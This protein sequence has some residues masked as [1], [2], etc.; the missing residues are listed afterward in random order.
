[1][2]L[3][4]SWLYE[5]FKRLQAI[6][7]ETHF[8]KKANT[9]GFG[10]SMG[11]N[12]EDTFQ[13]TLGIP[14]LFLMYFTVEFYPWNWWVKLLGK[15]KERDVI[16]IHLSDQYLDLALWHDTYDWTEGEYNGW[17]YIKSWKDLL[18]GDFRL[19]HLNASESTW[20]RDAVPHLGEPNGIPEA[21]W[22]IISTMERVVWKRWYMRL[23]A[24]CRPDSYTTYKVTPLFTARFP[25]KNG[26]DHLVNL[27]VTTAETPREA[28]DQFNE[29]LTYLQTR[30]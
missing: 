29:R 2:E 15:A 14:L 24:K 25:G 23:W 7:V 5:R 1:M 16:R 4:K 27:H 11:R 18:C 3:S 8:G 19:E 21:K 6:R 13:F 22:S 17:Y 28:I 10:I 30:Y 26:D 9:L 12:S 20:E